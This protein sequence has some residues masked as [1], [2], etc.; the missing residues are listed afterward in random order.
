MRGAGVVVFEECSVLL[1]YY[2][3]RSEWLRLNDRTIYVAIFLN[4]AFSKVHLLLLRHAWNNPI[5]YMVSM[6]AL[7]TTNNS[8]PLYITD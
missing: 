4:R 3:L 8:P 1:V 7:A 2:V 5:N 6:S